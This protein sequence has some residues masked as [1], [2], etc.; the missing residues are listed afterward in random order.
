M[1]KIATG[2]RQIRPYDAIAGKRVVAVT[3]EANGAGE[4]YRYAIRLK[5]L[6]R[7]GLLVRSREEESGEVVAIPIDAFL[8]GSSRM[9][10]EGEPVLLLVEDN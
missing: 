1:T 9:K 10:I 6:A 5:V 4:N 3:C 8:G 2:Y 7:E